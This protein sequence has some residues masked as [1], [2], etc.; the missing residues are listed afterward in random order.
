MAFKEQ[1][2]KGH[3]SWLPKV[4]NILPREFDCFKFLMN[5]SNM[6]NLLAISPPISFIDEL[7]SP[8]RSTK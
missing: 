4:K 6:S 5:D 3:N 8:T 2:L 7:S 1:F